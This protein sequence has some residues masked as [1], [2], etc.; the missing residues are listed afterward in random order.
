MML[1]VSHHIIMNLARAPR[2]H[3]IVFKTS[4]DA[5]EHFCISPIEHP[6][7]QHENNNL[8][9]T[10]YHISECACMHMPMRNS[11]HCRMRIHIY[12]I[13]LHLHLHCGGCATNLRKLFELL[14]SQRVQD[15][16]S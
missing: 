4:A 8:H 10:V 2:T 3:Y 5:A 14:A 9:T 15:C 6:D 13:C 7:T 12:K 1:L 16:I 11:R